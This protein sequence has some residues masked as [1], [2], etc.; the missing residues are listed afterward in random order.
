MA[1]VVEFS[2]IPEMFDQIT[3]KFV[4]EQRP[5]LMRKLE[6][7]Y[8]GI[9]FS[10]F[11]RS[12]E[13]FALGLASLGAVDVPI[14]PTLTPPQIAYILNDSGSK[15]VVA[16]NAL[17]VGKLLKILP[18]R[19]AGYYTAMSCGCT[20][21]YAGSTETVRDNLLEVRPTVVTTVPRLFERIYSR[22]M[23]QVDSSAGARR[24]IFHWAI[25]VGR[26]F[27]RQRRQN[28]VSPL[29]RVQHALADRLVF[30]KLKARTGGRIRFFVSGGATLPK[31]LGEFF[32]SVGII[33]IEGYGLTEISPVLTGNRVDDYKHGTVGKPIPGV[34]IKIADDGEILAN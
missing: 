9:S 34:E 3:M 18:E 24:R 8:R 12:V 1:V 5:M 16:S 15:I 27:A 20:V 2:T 22:I 32:E 13:R 23:K 33:I 21:A 4:N 14:Y 17:Q 25:G 10:Q 29:T 30:S 28:N 26:E 6:G 31:D 19:M 11:R 7:E